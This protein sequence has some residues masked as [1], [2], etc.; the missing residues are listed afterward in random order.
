VNQGHAY[1]ELGYK[2][3]HGSIPFGRKL[4]RSVVDAVVDGYCDVS[5]GVTCIYCAPGP[6]NYLQWVTKIPNDQTAE[7]ESSDSDG[8]AT[9]WF[10]SA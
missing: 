7:S 8:G 2:G 10:D 4:P 5:H 3:R 1:E 9:E 6:R